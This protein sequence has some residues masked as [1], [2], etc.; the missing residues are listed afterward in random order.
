MSL[1][2]NGIS[3]VKGHSARAHVVQASNASSNY[4]CSARRIADRGGL[5]HRWA[6]SSLR[7][8]LWAPCHVKIPC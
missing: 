5:Q 2:G 3:A 8:A 1:G 4:A 7:I 6:L